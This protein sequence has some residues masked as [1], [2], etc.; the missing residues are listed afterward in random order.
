MSE[1]QTVAKHRVKLHFDKDGNPYFPSVTSPKSFK[2]H[3]FGIKPPRDVIPVVFVPGVMGTNLCLIGRD[4]DGNPTG[5]PGEAAWTPPN[6][7]LEKLSAANKGAKERPAERQRLRDPNNT[8]VDP[9][10]PCSVPDSVFWLTSEEARNRRWHEP[11]TGSYLNFLCKLEI[12]LNDRWIRPGYLRKEGNFELEEIGLLK[13]LDGGP[14]ENDPSH[15]QT[16]KIAG[17]YARTDYAGGAKKAM[18]AWGAQPPALTEDEIKRLE[19]YYYPVWAYGYNWLRCN[20]EAADGLV[21]YIK[22][23]VLARYEGGKDKDGKEKYFRHQ[24]KVIIVTH[25]MGGLVARRAAQEIPDTILGVVHGAQPVVGAAAVY[26]RVKSGQDQDGSIVESKVADVIG[27]TS[28]RMTPQ[29]ACSPGPLELAPTRDYPP[30]WLKATLHVGNSYHNAVPHSVPALPVKDPYTEIY[31]KTTD[32]CWWG[33]IDPAFIDPAEIIRKRRKNP[34]DEYKN[35]VDIAKT[36]H[37]KL[38]LYAHRETYGFYGVDNDKYRA[39]GHVEWSNLADDSHGMLYRPDPKIGIPKDL[40]ERKVKKTGYPVDV[41]SVNTRYVYVS[42][43]SD[44]KDDLLAP[45]NLKPGEVYEKQVCFYLLSDRNQA[46]DGTVPADS[47]KMLKHLQPAPKMVFAMSGFDHQGAYNDPYT[48]Q[49]TVYFIA[50]IIQK[51]SP[52]VSG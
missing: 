6:S 41:Y 42:L 7:A 23:K 27:R 8:M 35:A 9:R 38:G 29:L 20:G 52:P 26:R 36:F 47:G 32:D 50:R 24:G 2:V 3:A 19:Q 40:M 34:L 49:A 15:E 43:P 14:S 30:G 10:G 37:D 4:K 12:A 17:I 25:S 45:K 21:K 39:Y 11:H 1:Q 5:E 48:Y 22:E 44:T 18:K 16:R 28:E 31:S 33:M 13:Y 46:G 51:A